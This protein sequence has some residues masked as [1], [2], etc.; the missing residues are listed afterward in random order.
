MANGPMSTLDPDATNTN[1]SSARIFPCCSHHLSLLWWWTHPA[2][3][4]WMMQPGGSVHPNPSRLSTHPQPQPPLQ[5]CPSRASCS[6]QFPCSGVSS[7]FG[8][9]DRALGYIQLVGPWRLVEPLGLRGSI[10]VG[11]WDRRDHRK[12]S[13]VDAQWSV[14]QEEPEESIG[15]HAW[16]S[17]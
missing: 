12:A 1:A 14:G 16:W 15:L 3:I 8:W 2:P 10:W 9:G 17:A 7:G 13:R 4:S 11:L 5:L 6:P